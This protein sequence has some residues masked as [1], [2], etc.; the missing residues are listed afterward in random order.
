MGV[1]AIKYQAIIFLTL[2]SNFQISECPTGDLPEPFRYQISLKND[3]FDPSMT[4]NGT[5]RVFS[6]E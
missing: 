6:W 3:I 5:K 4:L 2:Q 1:N